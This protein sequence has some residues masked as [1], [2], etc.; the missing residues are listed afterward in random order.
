MTSQRSD[1]A[2]NERAI[3]EAAAR[4]LSDAPA[5]GMGEIAA[6]AELGRATLYRHFATREALIDGLRAEAFDAVDA[7]IARSDAEPDGARVEALVADLIEVGERYQIVFASPPDAHARTQMQR[8]F[9]RP[10]LAL[11]ERAQAEGELAPDVPPT[12]LLVALEAALGGALRARADG[13]LGRADAKRF[14]LRALLGGFGAPA[15]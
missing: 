10:L 2:R 1:F 13:R 3:I 8:R 15:A 11:L 4:V 9:D 12:W 5:A 7:A 6:A 14:A